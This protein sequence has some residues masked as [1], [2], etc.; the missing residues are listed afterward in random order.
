MDDAEVIV[1]PDVESLERWAQRELRFPDPPSI[2][3]IADVRMPG[4]VD[5]YPEIDEL[6]AALN[7]D[8]APVWRTRERSGRLAFIALASRPTKNGHQLAAM[9][10][11][12]HTQHMMRQRAARHPTL[13]KLALRLYDVRTAR[14]ITQA[15]MGYMLSVSR[16]TIDRWENGR[17]PIPEAIG[18]ALDALEQRENPPKPHAPHA[19]EDMEIFLMEREATTS[20]SARIRAIIRSRWPDLKDVPRTELAQEFDVSRQLVASIVKEMSDTKAAAKRRA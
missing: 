4:H 2:H 18:L 15:E 14:R 10:A 20:K 12:S 3:L 9:L 8:D 7:D 16:A 13:S 17:T 6:R 1:R 11:L 19:G 5:A